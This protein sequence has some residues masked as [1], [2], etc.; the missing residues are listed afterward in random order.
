V[1]FNDGTS[2]HAACEA[3]PNQ[4][5]AAERVRHE[6]DFAIA[7]AHATI[8]CSIC[9]LAPDSGLIGM[10]RGFIALCRCL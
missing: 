9:W 4:P 1:K 6:P 7:G 8:L 5:A 10:R 3:T 2:S